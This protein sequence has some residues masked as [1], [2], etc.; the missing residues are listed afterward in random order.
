MGASRR[1]H[2]AG[3]GGRGAQPGREPSGVVSRAPPRLRSGPPTS[4]EHAGCQGAARGGRAVQAPA[5]RPG[6]CRS[7]SP[8]PPLRTG[9]PPPRRGPWTCPGASW[10]PGRSAC[11]QVRGLLASPSLPE[12][13]PGAPGPRI[14]PPGSGTRCASGVRPWLL[15]GTWG[16]GN[17]LQA[18]GSAKF[19]KRGGPAE[20]TW[21]GSLV[22]LG[23]VEEARVEKC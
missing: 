22:C 18:S 12:P 19:R 21:S 15:S 7:G 9:H 6:G 17:W 20:A 13:L 23:R 5:P 4:S 2:A 3:P 1:Q 11:G 14:L 16:S 10:W 8:P